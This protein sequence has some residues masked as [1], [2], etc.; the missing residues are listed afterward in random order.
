MSSRLP[1][2]RVGTAVLPAIPGIDARRL[3]LVLAEIVSGRSPVGHTHSQYGIVA[4]DAFNASAYSTARDI[5]EVS[6]VECTLDTDLAEFDLTGFVNQ[7][8]QDVVCTFRQD[9]TGGRS[10]GFPADWDWFSAG[11]GEEDVEPTMPRDAE[12]TMVVVVHSSDGGA[13]KQAYYLGLTRTVL[14]HSWPPGTTLAVN[15][16]TDCT[17]IRMKR[18][19][20]FLRADAYC[21]TAPATTG[22]R[23]DIL[24]GTD[25]TSWTTIWTNQDNR[26]EIAAAGKIAPAVTTFDVPGFSAGDFLVMVI[27]QVGAAGNEGAG[28]TVQLEILEFG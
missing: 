15:S 27:D 26:P 13:T 12:A 14:F 2:N 8:P 22:I 24:K 18:D 23:P 6:H 25:M 10:L 11:S 28:L 3:D 7:R 4:L 20:V 5:S 21:H 16:A 17:P 19:G 9:A 1:R